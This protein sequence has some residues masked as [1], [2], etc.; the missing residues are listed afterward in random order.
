[1]QL[2]GKGTYLIGAVIAAHALAFLMLG[3]LPEPA[4]TALGIQS[5][6]AAARA[7]FEQT[8]L[9]RSY[10]QTLWDLASG[11]LGTTLDGVPVLNEL[12]Q[13]LQSSL[14]RLAL[15]IAMLAIGTIMV[16]FAN[17]DRLKAIAEGFR[18]LAFL[19]PFAA[20][21]LAL[22]VLLMI[23]STH[24]MIATMASSVCITLPA[25]AILCSQTAE[26]TQRNLSAPFAVN[27]RATGAS[28]ARLRVRLLRSLFVE[29]LP[30]MEKIVSGLLV[31]LIF[32][33][34]VLGLDGFGTLAIRAIRR[35]DPDMVLAL[36]LV[37]AI[38]VNSA[39]ILAEVGRHHFRL[40]TQ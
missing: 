37:V 9:T 19:P 2:V 1:M 28:N 14:P 8:H 4:I 5:G 10:A 39:R 13:S 7:A 38:T 6:N 31:S 29:L 24:T 20:P 22:P 27:I 17:R 18:F 12:M 11:N 25:L 15:A 21:F 30:T 3:G 16:A 33:E 35:S 34:P 32:V 23:S 26:V 36:V 40:G